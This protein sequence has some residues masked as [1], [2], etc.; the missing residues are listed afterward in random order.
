M[1]K[2]GCGGG[3]G[4]GAYLKFTSLKGKRN[5]VAASYCPLSCYTLGKKGSSK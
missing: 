5:Q 3:D 4:K 1:G 2:E